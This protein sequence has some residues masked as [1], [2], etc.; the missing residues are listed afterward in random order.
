MT[1]N[2]GERRDSD[3]GDSWFKPSENRYRTQSDYQDPLEPEE[4][5]DTVFPDSGGYAGLSSSR[6]AMVEPYPEALGGPPPPV[7]HG[8]SY[9]GAGSSAYQPLT[10]VPGEGEESSLPSVAASAQ[11]PLPSD[12]APG[13]DHQ[14]PWS[15]GSRTQEIPA[16]DVR[17]TP[18][19]GQPWD[20]HS[21]AS[22]PHTTGEQPWGSGGPVNDDP[23]TSS[24]EAPSDTAD[25][26]RGP[27]AWEADAPA[28][29]GSDRDAAPWADASGAGGSAGEPRPWD[30]APAGGARDPLDDGPGTAPWEAA[31]PGAADAR[32]W[33]DHTRAPSAWEADAPA[34]G[35]SDRDQAPW[36]DAPETGG[37][38]EGGSAGGPQP[39]DAPA[40]GTPGQPWDDAAPGRA[41]D[42]ADD[43]LGPASW[44]TRS[45]SA[46]GGRPWDEAPAGGARDPL[47]DGPGTAPWEAAAPGAADARPWEDHTRAPSAWDSDAPAPGGHD[48]DPAPWPEP[49]AGG[50]PVEG[51]AQ[52]WDGGSA[53]DRDAWNADR[54]GQPWDEA[55]A[56]GARDP[57]DDG[58]GPASWEAPSSPASGGQP[59][60][61][62]P[63]P[64]DDA[65]PG[66]A[67]GGFGETGGG[68]REFGAW[69]ADAPAPDR[70]DPLDDGLGPASWEAQSSSA[71]GQPWGPDPAGERGA[72]NAD[73]GEQPWDG[74]ARGSSGWNDDASAHGG[75][76]GPAAWTDVPGPGGSSWDDDAPADRSWEGDAPRHGTDDRGADAW[77]DRPYGGS[78]DPLGGDGTHGR[79]WDDGL[80]GDFRGADG[81]PAGTE[82]PDAWAPSDRAGAGSGGSWGDGY[83][84]ELSPSGLGTGTGNTWA[85]D[86]ND[87][88]LPDVVREAE[89][90]RR[91]SSSGRA[92]TVDWGGPDTGELSAAVP[93]ADDPLGAIADMQSRARSR[94]QE[95]A[96]DPGGATQ[97]FDARALAGE[98]WGDDDGS[99]RDDHRGN[100]GAGYGYDDGYDGGYDDDGYDDGPDGPEYGREGEAERPEYGHDDDP[101]PRRDDRGDP[102][103]PED[104]EY[105]DGFTPAD[106]GMPA[107]APAGRKRRKDPIADDFPGFDDRPLGGEAGD[108]YPGYDSIDFLADTERGAT[109]TLWLGL[110]SLLP[111]VGLVTA[112]L[113]L[114]VTGPRAKRAIRESRGQLDGLG[115]ITTGTVFAVVG[116]LVTVISVA[117][118]LVL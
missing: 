22:D 94:D 46:T 86:R 5:G 99:R 89:Q 12:D 96:E 66:T 116:I 34:R 79:T 11:V 80:G 118:W 71:A 113:A 44:E 64:G 75:D 29:G 35:G 85:F 8:I 39:W 55:P 77:D 115:L 108:A 114:L 82:A 107:A 93:G 6:P 54:G 2:G 40:S 97:M 70:R 15:D 62:T 53:G 56:G 14:E 109:L 65:V 13:A 68:R 18:D 87:P 16:L 33:E 49:S 31:A 30:E 32:P 101:E 20:A 67:D 25:G 81:A 17:D 57:L 4:T 36:P 10:R 21:S 105:E 3:S 112:L 52:P 42:A 110:A 92:E 7:S 69:G 103:D 47:D 104:P 26:A 78:D 38:A 58:L 76:R 27:A 117:L 41:R 59:W 90:R 60:D 28:R 91:E 24:W 45:S 88:R 84:D 74:D 51:S 100:G 83:G 95:Q 72:R 102:D 48:R 19:G 73:R 37:S 9:P 61:G 50:G 23:G 111:G 1:D 98:S 63:G 106:Y 43:G